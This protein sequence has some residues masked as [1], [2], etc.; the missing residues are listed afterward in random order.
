MRDAV[1]R[2]RELDARFCEMAEPTPLVETWVGDAEQELER[3]ARRYQRNRR[4]T[5]AA[6]VR[7][8]G[9]RTVEEAHAAETLPGPLS[10]EEL[11]EVHALVERV[12]PQCAP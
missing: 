10:Q 11:A 8:E 6:Q 7:R 1:R 5:L 9:P 3:A 12:Q 2:L 4:R